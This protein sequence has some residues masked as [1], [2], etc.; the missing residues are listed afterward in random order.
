MQHHFP[1]RDS[2]IVY[3]D[4]T[5]ANLETVLLLSVS[6]ADIFVG[7]APAKATECPTKVLAN[8]LESSSGLRSGRFH[9]SVQ[10]PLFCATD[11][12]DTSLSRTAFSCQG[13]VKP[14]IHIDRQRILFVHLCAARL[15]GWALDAGSGLQDFWG[16]PQ[17]PGRDEHRDDSAGERAL[18][19]AQACIARRHLQQNGELLFFLRASRYA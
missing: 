12:G 11:P 3:G 8:C 10:L 6:L 5:F 17:C 19:H 16:G 4:L 18:V 13:I 1:L 9:P 14:T 7:H 2:Q 15:D